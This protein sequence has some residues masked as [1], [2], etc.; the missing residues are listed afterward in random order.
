MSAP[1]DDNPMPYQVSAGFALHAQGRWL[2]GGAIQV[3]YGSKLV[4]Q[5]SVPPA[6]WAILALLA[7]AAQAST[8]NHWS[9][10]FITSE[11]LATKLRRRAGLGEGDL[12][13]IYATIKKLRGRPGGN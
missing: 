3:Y 4:A 7:Q 8:G 5:H 9:A 1:P 12:Q 11:E 6:E 10:A 2:T 13:N